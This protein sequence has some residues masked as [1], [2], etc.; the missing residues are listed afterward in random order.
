MLQLLMR[1][2]K[3]S[4]SEF[5]LIFAAHRDSTSS[6]LPSEMQ[7]AECM[8]DVY[9]EDLV[10][11]LPADPS[12]LSPL[13]KEF[14]GLTRSWVDA[15]AHSG[16]RTCPDVLGRGQEDEVIDLSSGGSFSFTRVMIGNVKP[17]VLK[18]IAE[19]FG[20]QELC[21]CGGRHA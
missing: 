7:N 12:T 13:E 21:R 6:I 4:P 19:D 5:I 2:R 11:R 10:H 17:G 15:E 8:Q 9:A 16:A 20:G 18:E 1:Y 14:E 3:K